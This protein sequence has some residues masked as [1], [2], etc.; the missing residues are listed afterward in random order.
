MRTLIRSVC[1]SLF[2]ATAALPISLGAVSQAAAQGNMQVEPAIVI[3]LANVEE[4]NADVRHLLKAAG[5]AGFGD[6]A[7]GMTSQYTEYVDTEKPM[8]GYVILDGFQP[9]GV[10]FVPVKDL[11]AL[12]KM[13]SN[14]LGEIEEGDDGMRIVSMPDGQEAFIKESGGYAFISDNVD[15]LSDLPD[16]PSAMLDGLNDEYNLAIRVYAQR[17]P[18]QMKE[19]AKG[20]IEEGFMQ[21]IE[22]MEDA[23]P[24][25]AAMQRQMNEA[26]LQSVFEMIDQTDELTVGLAIDEDSESTYI[27]VTM[28]GLPDSK[29]AKQIAASGDVTTRFAGF[30]R[31]SAAASVHMSSKLTDEDEESIENMLAQVREQVMSQI[32]SNAPDPMAK[33]AAKDV[34]N[35]LFDV[36]GATLKEGIIDGGVALVLDEDTTAMAAGMAVKEGN[37]I[38]DIAKQLVDFAKADAP[39]EVK[40]NLN[41]ETYNGVDMHVITVPVPE[42]EEDLRS[43]VGETMDIVLGTSEDAFYFAGGKNSISLLKECMDASKQASPNDLPSSQF[44]ISLGKV[45][46]FANSMQDDPILSILADSVEG[47][48]HDK[49]KVT[50]RI[51]KN[52]AQTRIEFEDDIIK[53]IGNAGM[54]LGAGGA[55]PF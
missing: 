42:D 31:D 52:G 36:L 47:S 5:M 3:S 21:A 41:A 15:N 25:A 44:F 6:W 39:P 29:M 48:E 2:A 40:F 49:F 33:D 20:Y 50:S 26:T 46:S 30:F 10:G 43:A 4:Q 1:L 35:Q 8:G 27:D 54:Q 34:T 13:L 18:Q 17:L 24:G 14:D 28:T 16:N 38:A 7:V 11:D 9:M 37:K 12:L 22:Q 55:P 32:D 53:L 23:D 19:M 51:V 45:L